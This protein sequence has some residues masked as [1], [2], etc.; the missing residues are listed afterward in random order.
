MV[1]FYLDWKF[2]SVAVAVIALILSQLPPIHILL[3]RAKLDVEVYN[4]ML[5]THKVGNPNAQ[6]HLIISNPGG[7]ELRIK[8][9]ALRLRR[10]KE[11]EFVLPAQNYLQSPGDKE[12]VL[13]TSFK[14]KPKEEWAH[15][16][17]FLNFFSRQ[18]EKS[19]RQLE[20]NLRQDILIKRNALVDQNII[21]TANDENVQP[22]LKFFESKFRWLPGEYELTLQIQV[23]PERASLSRRYRI[24]LFESDSKELTDYR[25][26]YKYGFGVCLDSQRHVGVIVPLTET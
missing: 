24:T 14:L 25:D 9:I 1:P 12:A 3:R 26:D 11:D 18:D 15:I 8:G 21:A 20:S 23:E 5:L 16:V 19:Y 4:R 6:L 13:L 22:L 2:W 7:R 17:N 10:G